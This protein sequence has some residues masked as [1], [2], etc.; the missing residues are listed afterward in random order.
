LLVFIL[1]F[2]NA[3]YNIFSTYTTVLITTKYFF[4]EIFERLIF[5]RPNNF[6]PAN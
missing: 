2:A 3:L 1:D 6:S 5:E 4:G